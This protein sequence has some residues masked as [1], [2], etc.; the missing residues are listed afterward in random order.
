MYSKWRYKLVSVRSSLKGNLSLFEITRDSVIIFQKILATMKS[1]SK[2]TNKFL[3]LIPLCIV[4]SVPKILGFLS[5]RK[6][7]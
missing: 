3:I 5:L 4:F 2:V 1:F 7:A 6:I